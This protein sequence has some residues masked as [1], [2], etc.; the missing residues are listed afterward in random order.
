MGK[1]DSERGPND[2]GAPYPGESQYYGRDVKQKPSGDRSDHKSGFGNSNFRGGAEKSSGLSSSTQ[3][4][5][6]KGNPGSSPWAYGRSVD[7]RH[8][9]TASQNGPHSKVGVGKPSNPG[10][11]SPLYAGNKDKSGN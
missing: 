11:V 5:N 8:T 1:Y 9:R 3:K 6:V 10:R 2:S 7:A 4:R